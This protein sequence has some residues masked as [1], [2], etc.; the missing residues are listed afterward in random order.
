MALQ[1]S[2]PLGSWSVDTARLFCSVVDHTCCCLY[3]LSDQVTVVKSRKYLTAQEKAELKRLEKEG[4]VSQKARQKRVVL[5][6][7][8]V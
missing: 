2:L 7:W 1:F 3:C 4:M 6:R 5:Q 8:G